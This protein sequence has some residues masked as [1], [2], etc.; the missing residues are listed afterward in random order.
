MNVFCCALHPDFL[1]CP[2]QYAD[3]EEVDQAEFWEIYEEAKGESSHVHEIRNVSFLCR[4]ANPSIHGDNR[5]PAVG[6]R[7]IVALLFF[8]KIR[9]KEVISIPGEPKVMVMMAK[10]IALGNNWSHKLVNQLTFRSALQYKHSS[11]PS[12][13]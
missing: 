2:H 13:R 7:K 11:F 1:C 10:D 12:S 3:D 4:L 8:I 5:N 9:E 6:D